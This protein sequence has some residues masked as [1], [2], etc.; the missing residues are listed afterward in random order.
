MAT[1][2]SAMVLTVHFWSSRQSKAAAYDLEREIA[3]IERCSDFMAF[4]EKRCADSPSELHGSDTVFLGGIPLDVYGM[5]TV[6]F[7]RTIF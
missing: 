3:D 7:C 4:A 1:F 2:L 6:Q 5:Y